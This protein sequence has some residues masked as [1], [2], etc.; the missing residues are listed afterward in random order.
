[1]GNNRCAGGIL[2]AT[3]QLIHQFIDRRIS[4]DAVTTSP[5]MAA[6]TAF[7]ACHGATNR[8]RVQAAFDL[9]DDVVSVVF[10]LFVRVEITC[11]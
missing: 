4:Q 5:Q 9:D 11:E 3:L 6:I 2:S 10:V 8:H 1:M 7:V